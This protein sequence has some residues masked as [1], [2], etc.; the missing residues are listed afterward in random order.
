MEG[1]HSS[2]L[3]LSMT[4][5]YLSLPV[6]ALLMVANQLALLVGGADSA[7]DILRQPT[8]EDVEES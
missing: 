6:G 4:I 7:P 8:V 2:A 1:R 5:P 3:G